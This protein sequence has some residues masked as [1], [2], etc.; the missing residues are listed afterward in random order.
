M[1]AARPFQQPMKCGGARIASEG[2]R[3]APPK[4]GRKG[5]KALPNEV[6]R[7]DRSLQTD[8]RAKPARPDGGIASDALDSAGI[9][10]LFALQMPDHVGDVGD[11][12]LEVALI[13]LQAAKPFLAARKAAVAAEAW[14]PAGMS[15][16]VHVFT[17]F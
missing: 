10:G 7:F 9:R 14:A 3:K 15:V 13:L 2:G 16:T 12:L 5:P 6:D 4:R 8:A 1:G 11:L 17:S